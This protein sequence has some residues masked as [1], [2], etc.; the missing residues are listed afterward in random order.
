MLGSPLWVA[1]SDHL[2]CAIT[3]GKR[4][5][6]RRPDVYSPAMSP[7]AT[8]VLLTSGLAL[9]SP[10]AV[11]AGMQAPAVVQA[12]ATGAFEYEWVFPIEQSFLIAGLGWSNDLNTS[13]AIHG[14]CFCDPTY[15]TAVVGD[16]LRWQ[17]FGNLVDPQRNGRARNWVSGC[18]GE[19]DF[20]YTTIVPFTADVGDPVPAAVLRF[21]SQPNPCRAWAAFHFELPASGR[22]LLRLH[23]LMGRRVATLLDAPQTAGG[24]SVDWI[25]PGPGAMTR[26]VYFARLEFAG[27]VRTERV[28]V[29][30]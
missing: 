13:G 23:D 9:M 27:Q 30:E 17:V 2:K 7:R 28:C 22:V 19:G 16:T 24:H 10:C 20:N 5:S 12:D 8:W 21:W 3:A 18:S 1:G 14:D 29:L 11:R 6:S 26:G 25:V 4:S 15:C